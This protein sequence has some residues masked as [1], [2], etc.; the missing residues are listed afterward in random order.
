VPVRK[1]GRWIGLIG[2]ALVALTGVTI[3]LYA[4]QLPPFAS[5]IQSTE[6]AYV[7]GQT[8]LISPQVSGYVT[9]VAVLDFQNVHAGDLLVR[10]DD[11]T[12]QQQLEQAR[13]QLLAAQANLAN[14]AQQRR[15]AEAS[16]VQARAIIASNTAQ[17][18]KT[19]ASLRRAERLVDD[20]LI[21]DQ[22]YDTAFA[23]ATQAAADLNQSRASLDVSEQSL[24]SV[25]VNRA[26]LEAA[27]ASAEARVRQAQID[28]DNTR[29]H[30]PRNGQLGQVA[31][32]QG[33]YVTNGTQLM[34]IVPAY[35]WVV[36]NFKETQMENVRIGQPATFT[37]DALGRARLTGHVEEISPATGSEFSVLPPDNAT[38]NFVKIAQRIPVKISVD[39]GQAL[40]AR[41]APGMSVVANVDTSVVPETSE[42]V[43]GGAAGTE[44]A[45]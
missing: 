41:L 40:A 25:D 22:D 21:S 12:Y 1:R 19:S 27:V 44:S 23:A 5:A 18:R 20:H 28:L 43:V 29:I 38:G 36:A 39:P 7:R 10:I 35:K 6:N 2:F 8:T 9:E 14:W 13:A 4:W 37:V 42:T 17:Q 34:A 3:V 16:I 11:R 15:T 45:K 26:V 24:R 32:R 31:V 30:A 33:A